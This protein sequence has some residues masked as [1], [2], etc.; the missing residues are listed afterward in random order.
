MAQVV[1][2]RQGRRRNLEGYHDKRTTVAAAASEE[3]ERRMIYILKELL[4][5]LRF[6]TG[7]CIFSFFYVVACRLP[8]GGRAAVHGRS[9]CD[10]CGRTPA[11]PEVIPIVGYIFQQGKCKGCGTAIP[12]GCFRA[13]VC[14]GAAFVG[15]GLCLGCGSTG[16]LSLRGAIMFCYLGIL[17][18][19]SLTDRETQII[20]DRFHILIL[21]L[22]ILAVGSFPEH[23]LSDRL[24]GFFIIALPMLILAFFIPGAFGGGDIKLMAASGWLLGTRAIVCA[25]FFG[26]MAGGF[27]GF[28][29]LKAGKLGRKDRFALGPFLAF[30]L[31][32]AVFWGD[33]IVQ[34]YL[35]FL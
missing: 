9:P 22:G 15:C 17:L 23:G 8:K 29:M 5:A 1:K 14:G 20:Y 25:M 3:W 7:A 2:S 33:L 21:L 31:T 24:L 4:W 11:V 6:F 26:L 18:M 27:Y 13:E 19:I 28:W 35:G 32:L 10:R 12:A 16:L 30:G 34:W